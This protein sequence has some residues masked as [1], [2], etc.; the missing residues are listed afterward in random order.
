MSAPPS[1]TRLPAI[2]LLRGVVMALM[3]VDHSS[4]AFNAGR[5]FTDAVQ[6]YHPGTPLPLGQFLLRWVTHLCAPTFLFLAGT[7]L[8]LWVAKQRTQGRSELS[9]DVH[10]LVRGFLIWAFELW[11][12]YFVMPK[13]MFL[14]QVLYAIGTSYLL[15]IVV[16]R[17]P[18]RLSLVLACAWIAFGEHLVTRLATSPSP[19]A[20]LLIVGGNIGPLI[21]AY[22]TLHWLALMMLGWVW[23]HRLDERPAQIRGK[24]LLTGGAL[25]IAFAVVRSINA[26]GNMRLLR[27]DGSLA[28]WLHVSKYP[29]SLSYVS[30]EIGLMCLA[31]A[32]CFA[33]CDKKPPSPNNVLLVLGQTP[34]LFYILHFPLLV[35]SAHAL[36]VE[37]H[38]GIPATL[39][40]AITVIAALYPVCQRYRTYKRNHP[41]SLAR[42]I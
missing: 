25:L 3:A 17:L 12:A 9:I 28:Q 10:L 16:R 5:L 8:A 34:M 11:I 6:F 19:V 21:V 31:L 23:G 33:L 4:E 30:L 32:A 7:G 2:D 24:L 1:K 20:K 42:F 35:I 27:D 36:G 15:M 38:L 40:G 37:H 39:L 14:F 18:R 13:G 22:P 29:P 41:E 26:Y